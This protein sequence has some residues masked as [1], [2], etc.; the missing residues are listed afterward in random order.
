MIQSMTAFARE[1]S[2]LVFGTLICELRSINHR[3]LECIVRLPDLLSGLES[4]IRTRLRHNLSRGKVE[5]TLHYYPLA[6]SDVSGQIN[7]TS[8][9]QL[10]KMCG[11]VLTAFKTHSV[12]INMLDI[13]KW[14]GVIEQPEISFEDLREQALALVEKTLNELMSV[15]QREGAVL[16]SLCFQRAEQMLF[17]IKKVREILPTVLQQQRE[18]IL[19]RFR[20]ISLELDPTRL[21]QEMLFFMQ[22][23]DVTEEIERMDAHL[24]EVKRILKN[25]NVVGRRLDFLMQELHREANTLGAK[26]TDLSI[27]RASLE[28]KV[29]IDQV[30]EQVQNL[31]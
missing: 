28:L 29:L 25:E 21:E 4:D 10:S 2:P 20:E 24:M 5:C 8:V 11:D 7:Q 12:H 23:I 13:L 17:E 18:R 6:V 14:P 31:Q 15:R 9:E 1:Q 22:K 26:S 3:Y 30:R 27:S 19:A 16:Q